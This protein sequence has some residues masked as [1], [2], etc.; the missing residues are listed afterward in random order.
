MNTLKFTALLALLILAESGRADPLDTWTVRNG[1]PP[2]NQ[3]LR[4]DFTSLTSV[5]YGGGQFVAVGNQGAILTSVDGVNWLQQQSGATNQLNAIAYG[6]GR[7]VAVGGE[8]RYSV[9]LDQYTNL[10]VVLTSP[11]GVNWDQHRFENQDELFGITY[12]NGQFVAVGGFFTTLI[13]SS[14]DGVDWTV[15]ESSPEGTQSAS[16]GFHGVVYGDGQFVAVGGRINTDTGLNE[17]IIATSPDGVTW[18]QHPSGATNQ[19][20]GV[21]YGNGL[22]VAVDGGPSWFSRQSESA[23]DVPI[24][25]SV[26]GVT[27]VQRQSGTRTQLMAVVHGNGQF[28]AVGRG[29]TVVTSVD[30][31]RW[32]A[33]QARYDHFSVA[34]GGGKFVAVGATYGAPNDDNKGVIS[35][36]ADGRNWVPR[37]S[38][39]TYSLSSVAYGNGEFVAVGSTMLI[40]SNGVDWVQHESPP[41]SGIDFGNGQF[42]AVGAAS[43]DLTSGVI[44]T[45]VDGLNWTWRPSGTSVP[46]NGIV[47]GQGQFVAVGDGWVKGGI[48]ES[49]ILTSKDGDE[50]IQRWSGTGPLNIWLSA[51]AYGNGRFVAVDRV[52]LGNG[53]FYPTTVLISDDGANWVEHILTTLSGS[54]DITYGNGLFIAVSPLG[55]SYVL[56]SKDGLD[57]IE[58]DRQQSGGNHDSFAGVRFFNGQFI[59]VGG[60][61]HGVTGLVNSSVWTSPDGQNWRQRPCN[62]ADVLRS[63][64]YGDG[65]FVV[66]GD[67]ALIAESGAIINL[68]IAGSTSALALSLTGPVGL[69]YTVQTSTDLISWRNMTN[70]TATQSTSIITQARAANSDQ[71]YFRAYSK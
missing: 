52:G 41:L 33:H 24:L 44:G 32:S 60:Q 17:P 49:I 61:Y 23:S 19:L 42:V 66:V 38:D 26:D 13:L 5:A 48:H 4:R 6:K 25:T 2:G 8:Q 34:Y 50:W 7:F 70:F 20:H 31:V 10:T 43:A 29:G 14:A 67:N 59:A 1:L 35:T 16:D 30:G 62:S 37:L 54:D 57:W 12:G 47:Y 53:G 45:S 21:A 46:L 68:A 39:P 55:D 51:I 27:W 28:V 9:P 71:L 18:L 58:Q 69:G 22:F 40:S 56:V 63:V 11:D 64:A 36:S 15:R 65:H 3:S